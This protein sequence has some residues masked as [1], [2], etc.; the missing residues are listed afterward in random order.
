M[1]KIGHSSMTEA[2]ESS[3]FN[4]Y[5]GQLLSNSKLGV[6]EEHFNGNW[7]LGEEISKVVVTQRFHQT[8]PN[9]TQA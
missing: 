2:F 3:E 7:R 6:I 4:W 8:S 1:V 9:S 5:I